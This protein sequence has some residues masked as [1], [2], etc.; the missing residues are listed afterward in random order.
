MASLLELKEQPLLEYLIVDS[1][2]ALAKDS[3]LHKAKERVYDSFDSRSVYLDL[4][5]FSAALSNC[6]FLFSVFHFPLPNSVPPDWRSSWL[7]FSPVLLFF[8][9]LVPTILADW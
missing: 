9:F 6:E 8:V 3:C 7:Q 5:I 4:Y 2:W 1:K